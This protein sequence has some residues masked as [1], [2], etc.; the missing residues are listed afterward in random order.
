MSACRQKRLT[1]AAY[2][3]F[4]DEFVTAARSAFPGVL[5]QFEDFANHAAFHLLHKYRDKILHLQRR[6]PGHGRGGARRPVLGVARDRRQVVRT[7]SI[8]F[9]G[10]GEAATGIAEL[11]VSAMKAEGASEADARRRIW[12]VDS[13]GLVVK[14]RAGL[15]EQKLALRARP[16]RRSAISSRRSARSSRRRSS[17]SPRSAAPSRPTCSRR[18]PRSTSGRSSSP[19]PTRR[20]RPNARPRRPTSTPTAARCLPAAAPTTR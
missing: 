13:K 6:H 2:D 16:S 8:L 11:V 14:S 17:A 4:V 5:I 15:A 12:L 9:L 20:R 3:D 18:W 10:A 1:G 7:R 19:C